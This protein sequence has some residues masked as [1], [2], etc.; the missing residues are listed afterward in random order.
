M[1]L[2]G[3]PPAFPTTAIASS[4]IGNVGLNPATTGWVDHVVTPAGGMAFIVA[5]DA[6]DRYL[7]VRVEHW[8]RNAVLRR[9]VRVIFNPSRSLS[10]IT[11]GRMPWFRAM[12]PLQ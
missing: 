3:S 11:Q 5:E 1:A 7:V 8:T 6:L 9:I 10:N 4:S 12:R 2:I